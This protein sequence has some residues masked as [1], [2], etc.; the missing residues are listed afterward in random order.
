M[1]VDHVKRFMEDS[2]KIYK[3]EFTAKTVRI[4]QHFT[5]EA[6]LCPVVPNVGA[7][8]H[9]MEDA[10]SNHW[11]RFPLYHYMWTHCMNLSQKAP[12]LEMA[13]QDRK[14]YKRQMEDFTLQWEVHE[15]SDWIGDLLQSWT[16]SRFAF[17]FLKINGL[18]NRLFLSGPE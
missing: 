2:G 16:A 14:R 15:V 11:H 8:F 6:D 1:R 10:N 5:S 18:L 3:P 9:W 7:F 4:G 12:W 13:Y 17:K